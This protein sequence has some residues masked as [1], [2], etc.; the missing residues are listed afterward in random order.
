[1]R[2]KRQ[3][4]L[5]VGILTREQMRLRSIAIATGERAARK[6]EPKIWFT[7]V[8]SLAQVLSSKNQLLLEL[9]RSSKPETLQE[10]STKSGRAKGNLSKTLHTMEHYGLVAL[11]K[12]NRGRIK[13]TVPFD[14][15]EFAV[16]LS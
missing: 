16:P 12:D 9:I 5:R 15:L 7:S 6:N 13:P 4:I 10:L 8:E 3:R 1:M 14:R 11:T 2:R